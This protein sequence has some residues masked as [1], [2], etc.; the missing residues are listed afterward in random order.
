MLQLILHTTDN[1]ERREA[2]SQLILSLS[3]PSNLFTLMHLVVDAAQA[4]LGIRHLA[5]VL[6]RKR[7]LTLWRAMDEAQRVEMK[8]LLLEQLGKEESKVVRFA[9]AHIVTRLAKAGSSAGEEEDGRN[10]GGS[11]IGGGGEESAAGG[12]PEL[13]HAIRVAA[14]DPRPAMREL[15]MV[16]LYSV[17]EVLSRRS[18]FSDLA[19][20]AVVRGV[21]DEHEDVCRAAIKAG[22]MLLP[23]LHEGP[24][25]RRLCFLSHLIPQCLSQLTRYCTQRD[26]VG[27]CVNFVDI[28]EECV[29]ELPTGKKKKQQQQQ[30][31]H[32][33]TPSTPQPHLLLLEI[34]QT[35]SQVLLHRDVHLLIRQNCGALLKK[36]AQEKTEFIHIHGLLPSLVRAAGQLMAE[37]TSMG[38]YDCD[39]I[40]ASRVVEEE[41][42]EGESAGSSGSGEGSAEGNGDGG[43]EDDEELDMLNAQNACKIGR[44]LLGDLL[45]PRFRRAWTHEVVTMID[46]M[47]HQDAA[48]H[49]DP[50]MV[51]DDGGGV[52]SSTS[53]W[54][55]YPQLRK[56]IIFSLAGISEGNS[57]YLRRRVGE[58]MELAA[59]YLQDPSPITR[60]ATS[61][62]LPWFCVHLVPEILTH[63][64]ELFP[65]LIP[66]LQDPT[67]RVRCQAAKA[68]DVLCELTAEHLE[69][70]VH[71]LV[72]TVLA[73]LSSSSITTQQNLCSV[74]S[75]IASAKTESFKEF[76]TP[77]LE[78]LLQAVQLTAPKI[79]PLRGRALET[80]GVIA[81]SMG[82]EAFLPYLPHFMVHVE[83]NFKQENPLVREYTFGFLSNICEVLQEDFAP[84]VE[85]TI[86]CAIRT[87]EVDRAVY[88]NK[89]LLT[90][91]AP[92][93]KA[94]S[95]LSLRIPGKDDVL[96]GD[97]GESPGGGAVGHG[98][99]GVAVSDCSHFPSSHHYT[100]EDADDRGEEEGDEDS[101][102]EIHMC[103]RTADVEE[104]SAAVYII[105]VVAGVMREKLGEE[106]LMICWQTLSSLDDH[107]YPNIRS[108]ALIGL[109]KLAT[110]AHGNGG[111]V[112]QQMAH[113]TL[114]P[115]TRELLN[116]LMY[117]TLLPCVEEESEK[118]VVNAALESLVILLKFFGP[119]CVLFGPD[120]VIRDC[121]Q[122]MRRKLPCQQ[123][124]AELEEDSEEEDED[125][126]D[127]S[128]M[129][130]F[131]IEPPGGGDGEDDTNVPSWTTSLDPSLVLKGVTLPEEHDD[132]ILEEAMEVLEAVFEV[133]KEQAMPYA[134]YVIPLLLLYADPTVR[135]S[136]DVVMAVGTFASLL[137]SMGE[138]GCGHYA[139]LAMQLVVAV[140]QH[141]EESSA[142]SNAAYTLKVLVEKCADR[143]C[144]AETGYLSQALQLLWEI[145]SAGGKVCGTRPSP[146]GTPAAPSCGLLGIPGVAGAG[147]EKGGRSE[148]GV[149]IPEAVD[150]AISA[151]CSLVCCL[152]P[153]V[154]PF[155]TILPVL[156][157]HI[158]MQVDH[159]ENTNA[160]RALVHILASPTTQ[161]AL[162][163]QATAPTWLPS[164]FQSTLL[165]LQSRSV[166][167]ADKNRLAADGLEVFIHHYPAMWAQAPEALKHLIEQWKAAS[168][169]S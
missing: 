109:A 87:I 161:Q 52:P 74:L 166:T 6:L 151:T 108:N 76:A 79:L 118:D 116:S 156:F 40:K 103:V 143:F 154:L 67:D 28:L 98:Q 72:Q 62:S 105:G 69:P 89:H 16:L 127:W 141:S 93:L 119:Q 34:V 131:D 88:K 159:S 149:E 26:K 84:Y 96:C 137:E 61:G 7:I 124:G 20:E 18:A 115:F 5:A 25:G 8:R 129:K 63:H 75:S 136:E 3:E 21:M 92:N 164:L 111:V 80:V 77:V 71:H 97:G 19:A 64:H 150:N 46:E 135:P 167:G 78:L 56:S 9:I 91:D 37:D 24:R 157:A 160:V 42:D 133:Y 110:A 158:P 163:G 83:E 134:P 58:V 126:S 47:K 32:E 50:R 169:S 148:G 12:W 17:S 152:P 39:L 59:Q 106:R 53:S 22:I 94:F 14:E 1:N 27:L 60:E 123:D 41:E 165:M 70:Y 168:F 68:L 113:D 112:D 43:E 85:S 55:A 2:E 139:D 104:K 49:G 35:T 11:G 15:S 29:G 147:G 128:G 100:E 99:G 51:I 162:Q 90:K 153:C 57:G 130:M 33:P 125:G 142:R 4:S 81:C 48:A 155:D 36:V 66:L 146:L 95:R 30:Q 65:M 138:V 144:Q 31:H 10:G 86:E 54:S 132:E 101:E 140:M 82:K 102:A 23:I 121:I 122:I 45:V 44:Q 38:T 117:E 107:F 120:D 114:T 145:V 73:N 13:I